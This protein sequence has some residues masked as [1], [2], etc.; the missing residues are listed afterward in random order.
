MEQQWRKCAKKVDGLYYKRMND[1]TATFYG[2]Q[3]QEGI[4]FQQSS[5]YDL[6]MFKS[7]I[8]FTLELKSHTG[9]SLPFSC[10]RENQM[11]DL[12]KAGAH[13]DIV[14]GFVVFFSEKDKCY[15][16]DAS[17]MKHAQDNGGKKSISI[18]ECEAVGIE[19]GVRP[20]KTNVDYDVQGFVERMLPNGKC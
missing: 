17:Q 16:V 7:P 3:A 10:I 8:L 20:L 6:F 13:K 5:P 2:G 4:R 15:F 11:T 14:A 9:S 19:I 1:G 18:K 12:L